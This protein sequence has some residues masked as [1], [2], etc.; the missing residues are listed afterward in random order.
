MLTKRLFRRLTQHLEVNMLSLLYTSCVLCLLR[1]C[2]LSPVPQ[3]RSGSS[4][5]L[6]G[7]KELEEAQRFLPWRVEDYS[8]QALLRS[9]C[10]PRVFIL[11]VKFDVGGWTQRASI[12]YQAHLLCQL[13]STCFFF[14][15]T[16]VLISNLSLQ[17]PSSTIKKIGSSHPDTFLWSETVCFV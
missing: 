5:C 4:W 9:P 1:N 10:A 17:L 8:C 15:T 14:S 7:C 13:I 16:I 12:S 2:V 6:T 3:V 11:S